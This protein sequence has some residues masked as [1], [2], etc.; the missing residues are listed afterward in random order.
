M[1]IEA[2]IVAL[3]L[4]LAGV[5]SVSAQPAGE[6]ASASGIR[7]TEY[8]V[9]T[10]VEERELVGKGESFAEGTQVSFW[11]RIVGGTAGDRVRHVWLHE[12]K[13]VLSI[14][15]SVGGDHWR[16]YTNKTLHPGS[17]GA[18]VAEVR[19]ADERVLARQDFVC[20]KPQ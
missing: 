1:R 9:G 6:E 17:A 13:E 20:T 4:L 2:V 16:T 18:W 3:G 10:G 5:P 19:A 14:G 7:V 11:T 12:G 15:L 8:G